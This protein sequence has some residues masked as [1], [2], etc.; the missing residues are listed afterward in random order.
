MVRLKDLVDEFIIN[1]ILFQFQYGTIKSEA[2]DYI[3]GR[4]IISIPVWYD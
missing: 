2:E 4:K 1:D 3:L